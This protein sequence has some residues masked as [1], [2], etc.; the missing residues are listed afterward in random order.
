MRERL[1]SE[2]IPWTDYFADDV[3]GLRSGAVLM[4]LELDGLP[5]ETMDEAIIN[6]RHD[7]LEF[8]LRDAA[9][10]GLIFHFLQCRGTADPD[11]YPRG[12]F[13]SAFASGLDRH[14]QEKLFG[15][16]LMWLNRTYLA[17]ILAPRQ[18]GGR[19]LSR[20]LRGST[21]NEPAQE[22]IGR[23]QRITGVLR[24]QLK[25]YR[26]RVLSVERRGRQ[27]FSGIAEAVVFA[28]TGYWRAVPMT[29]AGAASIFSET[30]IVGHEAFEVRMPH[31]SNWGACLGIDEYPY[32]TS[33]GMFDAFL[34]A[35]YRHTI[36]HA[37]RCLASVDGQAL[38][39][40]QQNRLRQAGD[41]ALSQ[42]VELIEAADLIASNR[43]MI[44]EHACGV[45]V[46]ANDLA[47]LP[48]VVQSAWGDMSSGGI[49][50]ERENIALEAVLFSMIPGNFHLRGRQAAVS[51]R[52][53]AAFAS[54]HNFPRGDRK[55]FWSDPVALLRTSGGTPYLMHL[56]TDGVGNAL[57]TG[58]TGSG[59][60]TIIGFL[61]C[62]AERSGAQIVIWDKDKG[63]EALVRALDGSYL[64]L[65]N[66]PGLGSGL[67]PLKRLTN[68]EEDLS[69]LAGLLRACIATPEPYNLSAEEDRR[70]SIALRHVMALPPEIRS[71]EEV[72]AFLGT[73]RDGAG[74]RLEKWC[75]GNEFGWVIDCQRDIVAL[76]GRVIGF[77]QSALLEDPVASGA[78]LATLFHYTGK[79]VD[80]RRLLF[81]LDEVWNALL[82]PQ[83]H[84]EIH[85]GL[86]TW[87][88]YNAPILIAT[89]DVADG[90]S[91]P[92]GHTIRS[93]TPNQL[94]FAT[95]GAVWKDYGPEGMKLSATEF[96][97]IQK[98]PRGTGQFLLKQGDRSVV[99]QAD[100]SG[101]SEVAVISGTRRGAD[102]LILAR[103]RT[104]DA[105]GP[106]LVEAYHRALEELEE[107]T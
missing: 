11:I 68:S 4:M 20:F 57:I 88:K 36:F 92:I 73:S 29:T 72:R 80:G 49:K 54:M 76:D 12:R 15:G 35:S 25:E 22:L 85:N 1:L 42:A 8:A 44:G 62:Q 31:R 91:S 45:A 86:K 21:G 48:N 34:S 53:F 69:F 39:T 67:A 61:L 41:R 65:T 79:L 50:I 78:V 84:A 32:M 97:I 98:L 87:R 3:V 51:S 74:A 10:P 16:R 66:A 63:L 43:M 71:M 82:I 6:H 81:L 9:Q 96:D 2:Y 24:E 52:N 101:L 7:R 99:V 95:P 55:G 37:F 100:L 70:L 17:I 102:A 46:F 56:H 83:F 60:T 5:F 26:P 33:P 103:E 94:Y 19:T 13:H 30:F 59:K 75:S 38:A 18:V 77:D 47:D 89:Q 105:T 90:L 64:S 23:I 104:G 58:A 40:R 14:Y 107:A 106:E 27:L 28:M 93:Q